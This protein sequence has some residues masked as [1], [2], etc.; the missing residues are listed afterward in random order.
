M[1]NLVFPRLLNTKL[2][3]ILQARS[4]SEAL[5]FIKSAGAICLRRYKFAEGENK[6]ARK[7]RKKNKPK[8][9]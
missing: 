4:T 1:A 6:F 8:W 3:A 2:S 5:P 9:M 7:V